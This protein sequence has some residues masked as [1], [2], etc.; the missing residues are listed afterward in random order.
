MRT[1]HLALAPG[2]AG[3]IPRYR[4]LAA[5]IAA[6][7]ERGRLRPG[8]RLTSAR[9][10]AAE[11]GVNRKTV[12]A[13][14]E[15]LRQEGWVDVRGTGGVVVA[16]GRPRPLARRLP[17]PPPAP[18][19][20]PPAPPI[21]RPLPRQPGMRLLLGG[22]PDVRLMPTRELA[23]AYA[24]ALSGQRGRRALDYGDPQ[25]NVRLREALTG[26]LARTR[27][28]TVPT[29]DLCVVRGSQQGL[30]LI[31]HAL[32]AP[33]DVVAVETP[34]YPPGWEALRRAGAE[35]APIGVDGE[36]MD[37]D[38]LAE[39]CRRRP[40]RAVVVTPHHQYPTT[41]TLSPARRA[42][43]LAL[44]HEHRLIVIEDDYDF[45][46]HYDGPSILPLAARDPE[47]AVVYVATM[48][49]TLAPGL[50]LGYV[51]AHPDVIQRVVALRSWVDQQGDHL[52]EQAVAQLIEDGDLQRHTHRLR[53]VYRARRDSMVAALRQHLPALR[54]TVP[55]GGMA[56]W[57]E[58]PGMDTTA[59]AKRALALN[60]AI[61]AG[62]PLDITGGPNAFVR[63][64]F[65][66]CDDAE[67]EAAIAALAAAR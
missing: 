2:P 14:I 50:R 55:R 18:F 7:I 21:L 54:F 34:G 41:V 64:G 29:E 8:E 19:V 44:A 57:A 46:F 66:A 5:A 31:A 58:A 13:A 49:K 60:V 67:I 30:Y 43:L 33:G 65:A 12:M 4:A 16:A 52:V 42:R 62:G 25:G 3:D 39:L 32:L 35:L 26:M 6:D 48:S 36:G 40:V 23:R 56:L 38:A 24:S 61:Q 20:L 1:W 37:V 11:L 10:L 47:R 59:W 15:V 27:G 63:L 22:V 28:I 45:E 53:R 9:V 17:V 51:V